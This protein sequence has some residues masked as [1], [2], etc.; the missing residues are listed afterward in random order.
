MITFCCIFT[1]LSGL[2]SMIH[3]V[4]VGEKEDWE[5]PAIKA[6][7]GVVWLLI[8]SIAIYQLYH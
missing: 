3:A 8:G 6:I 2:I 7:G 5:S 4:V 1:G